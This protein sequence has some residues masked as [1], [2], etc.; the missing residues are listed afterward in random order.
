[1]EKWLVGEKAKLKVAGREVQVS[2]LDKI[3]FAHTGFNKAQLIDYYVRISKYIVPHLRDR[4]LTMKLFPLGVES[5]GV[6]RHNAPTYTPSWI[7][8]VKM[9]KSDRTG[10]IHSIVVNDLPTLVWLANASDVEMHPLL[11]RA[12]RFDQPTMMVF[13]LDPGPP[14]N[15]LDCAREALS[16][17]ELLQGMGLESVIKSSGSK[18]LHLCVPLNTS[19]TYEQTGTC[20]KL[21]AQ[22]LEAGHP[23]QVVCNMA[24]SLRKGKVF[25]DYSQ[26]ARHK[27]T[28]SVYSL[29]AKPDGPFVSMPIGWDEL[30]K[31]LEAGDVSPFFVRPEDALKRVARSGDLFEPLL[32][33]KQRLPR[34]LSGTVEKVRARESKRPP[35]RPASRANLPKKIME[36]SGGLTKYRA[37]RDFGVT[38]EPAGNGSSIAPH[39]G[40]ERLFVVQKHAASH[41]HY[42]FRLEMEGVL[43]SWA[44]P[45]GPPLKKSERRLAMHV[46]DHPL[47]YARFE[48]IIPRGQ[49][50]GGTVMVWDIGSYTVKT[51]SPAREFYQGR[52]RL[53]LKGKK[54]KGEWLLV[55]TKG[56]EGEK[57]AWLLI[58]AGAD[59]QPISPRRDDQSALTRRSMERI[60]LEKTAQWNSNHHAA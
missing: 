5:P 13:D 6:Y 33:M 39:K 20:A 42:D 48:G 4:P 18:G 17:R 27:S 37:K 22:L 28:A 15:I 44:V 21:V 2:S 50:G 59:A 52:M 8:K 36:R 41:L 26:N 54:L 55:R 1:V 32:K 49:Y 38:G 47:D 45:K 16:L 30:K 31:A 58:K 23:G 29:R 43:R 24:K 46:E 10:Q 57:E 56:E 25:V 3:L 53:Q 60:R 9:W 12:P 51:D 7:K 40:K 14:A 19:V 35:P 34:N 11:A